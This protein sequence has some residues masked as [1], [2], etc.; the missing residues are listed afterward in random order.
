MSTRKQGQAMKPRLNPPP[1]PPL[2]RPRNRAPRAAP[3][4]APSADFRCSDLAHF[5]GAVILESLVNLLLIVH[6][7]RPVARHRLVDRHSA[8]KK[9]AQR[10]LL[11]VRVH[12]ELV[13]LVAEDQHLRALGFGAARE[14]PLA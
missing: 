7:E 5:S 12:L 8:Q 13:A 3:S 6:H 1:E 10:L 2:R 4:N 11:R 14:D 9:K